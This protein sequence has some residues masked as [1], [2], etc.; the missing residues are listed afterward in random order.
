MFHRCHLLL[1]DLEVDISFIIPQQTDSEALLVTAVR[2]CSWRQ[3]LHITVAFMI[4]RQLDMV[5]LDYT[6]VRHYVTARQPTNFS[7]KESTCSLAITT[8]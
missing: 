5:G 3:G 6:T 2:A 7:N 4:N 1:F 8:F